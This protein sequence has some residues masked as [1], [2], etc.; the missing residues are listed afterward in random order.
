MLHFVQNIAYYFMIEVLEPQWAALEL[1]LRKATTVDEVLKLHDQFLDQCLRRC[2]LTH[3]ELFK[4]LAKLTVACETFSESVNAFIRSVKVDEDEVTAAMEEDEAKSGH[5][6]SATRRRHIRIKV[7][8][9][10]LIRVMEDESYISMIRRAERNFDD[11]L[12]RLIDDL[13]KQSYQEYDSHLSN[14][15]T[16]LDYNGFYRQKRIEASM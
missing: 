1:Q 13:V 15:C 10:H 14:L 16:R 9:N 6:L 7:E 5:R 12:G 2:L 11:L 3:P 8:S 4:L